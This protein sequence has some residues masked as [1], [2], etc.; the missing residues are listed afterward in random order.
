MA[1]LDLYI[2]TYSRGLVTGPTNATPFTLPPFFQGDTMSLRVYLL[3]RTTTFPLGTPYSIISIA[4]MTL[5]AAIGIKNGTASSTIY[6]AQTSWS[7]N[8]TDNYFYADFSL[9]TAGINSLIGSSESASSWF[10]IEY[11]QSG[12]PTTVFQ[13]QVTIHAEVNE[14]GT[15][16]SVP[17]VTYATVE[18]VNAAFVGKTNQ[19]FVME[20]PNTGNKV[21][22]YLHDDDT[23]HFDP[24][25]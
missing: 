12:F 6:A 5:K 9:A 21:Y 14:T 20:N 23:V 16:V 13:Q 4:G 10:E 8:T 15:L 17:G 2:D 1:R 25:T 3:E 18:Y 24:I 7:L 19:G 22:V 11:T